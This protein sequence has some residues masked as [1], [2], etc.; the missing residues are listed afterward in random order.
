[1]FEIIIRLRSG[2]EFKNVG[3]YKD[4]TNTDLVGKE[5]NNLIDDNRFLYLSMDNR[6]VSFRCSEIEFISVGK[7]R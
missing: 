3:N 6:S 7:K 1:M 2:Y 5:L 4:Y